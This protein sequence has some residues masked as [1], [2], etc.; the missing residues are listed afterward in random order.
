MLT[1]KNNSMAAESTVRQYM[2][3][4]Y[5]TV[6]KRNPNQHEFHQSVKI[7]F[8]SLVPV[9]VKHPIYMDK[10]VL[11]RFV[12]PERMVSFQ[13]PWVDDNGKV[14]VNRGYRVQFNSALGPYKGGIRFEPS[15]NLS[16]IKFLGFEQICKNSLTGQPIAGGRGGADFDPRGKPDAERMRCT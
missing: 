16:I 12:E 13:V 1:T 15:G 11:E 9:L 5:H 4:V 14:Q 8:R 2:D 7:L 3:E 10:G 6:E